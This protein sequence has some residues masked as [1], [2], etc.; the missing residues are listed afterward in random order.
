MRIK[1]ATIDEL[2]QIIEIYQIAREFMKNNGNPTQWADSYPSKELIIKD[3]EKNQLYVGV[4]KNNCI[5]YV[6]TFFIGHEEHYDKIEDGRWLN[7]DVYGVMH[8]IASD[9]KIKGVFQ[10]CADYCKEQINNIRIDTHKDNK[11]MQHVIEQNGFKR[12]GIIYVEDGAERIAYQYVIKTP[13][14]S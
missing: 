8:R 12:C 14:F 5:H 10:S 9:G 7:N 2:K 4:D 6:F 1:K 3:I 13:K 11:K